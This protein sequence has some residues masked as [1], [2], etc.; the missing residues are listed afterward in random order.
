MRS[1]NTLYGNGADKLLEQFVLV[2]RDTFKTDLVATFMGIAFGGDVEM[3]AR[4]W[5]G[6]GD[7]YGYDTFED[8]H[9]THLSY[10]VNS[11]EARCMDDVYTKFGKEELSLEWQRKQ[12]ADQGLGNAHLVKGLVTKDSCSALDHINLAWLDMDITAS[13]RTG[14]LAVCDKIVPGGF[15]ATHDILPRGHIPGNY[16]LFYQELWNPHVWEE[17]CHRDTCYFMAWRK[18]GRRP[19]LH[20]ITTCFRLHNLRTIAREIFAGT[21]YFDIKWHI[22]FDGEKVKRESLLSYADILALPFVEYRWVERW[23]SEKSPT[24]AGITTP[25]FIAA[26]DCLDRIKSGL[27]WINDDDNLPHPDF[28][29]VLSG[30][31]VELPLT[32]GWI[33]GQQGRGWIRGAHPDMVRPTQIDVAA[34]VVDRSL[35]GDTRFLPIY[36][37]DGIFI[38][39]IY[40]KH[41]KSFGFDGRVLCY[42]N[43]LK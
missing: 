8:G 21:Q 20:I 3:C 29:K 18:L 37:S 15:L 22:T 38:A 7:V 16:E 11:Y 25:S 42:H 2:T 41:A 4:H 31:C 14:Y 9:P 26:N 36:A 43:R 23:S 10:D 34:Y 13:M 6:C 30:R 24:D 19:L 28:F 33:V 39:E 40:Q 1:V 27:V 17:V 12:L 32:L 5:L 35:I